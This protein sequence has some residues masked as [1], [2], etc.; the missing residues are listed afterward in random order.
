MLMTLSDDELGLRI[1]GGL[2]SL[3]QAT[4]SFQGPRC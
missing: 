1:I 2:S 3:A 4:A